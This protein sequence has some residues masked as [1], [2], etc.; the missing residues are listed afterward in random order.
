MFEVDNTMDYIKPHLLNNGF[1]EVGCED[2]NTKRFENNKCTVEV[3][4]N[5]KVYNILYRDKGFGK[6]MCTSD[7]LNIYWLFGFLAANDLIDRNFKI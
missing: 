4:L 6:C 7:N 2:E 1:E 3:D 5:S